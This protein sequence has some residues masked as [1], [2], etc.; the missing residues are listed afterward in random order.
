M[1]ASLATTSIGPAL[2]RSLLL[3]FALPGILQAFMHAPAGAILQGV[4]A[5]ESGI[6][7]MALGSAVLAVR[8]IDIFSDLL[9]GYLSDYTA[10]RGISRKL[11][12]AAGTVLTVLALWFLFRPP[13]QVSVMYYGFWF[14]MANIGWSLVEIP[15]RSWSLEFSPEPENRTRIVTWIAVASLVG[16]TVFYVVAPIG[17]ALGLLDT[18]EINM[19][20]LGLV[21]IVVA[22]FLPVL[23][24]VTLLRV[25]DTRIPEAPRPT[26]E[27]P[28][29]DFSL[30]WKSIV[31][32]APLLRFIACFALYT[33]MVGMSQ[34]VTLLYLTNYLLLSSSVNAVLASAA[35]IAVLGIPVWGWLCTK[36]PRQRVW[37]A[38]MGLA[39]VFY[40]CMGLLPPHPS[41][42]LMCVLNS[43]VAFCIISTVVAAPVIIGDII[44]YGKEKFGV[45]RAGLYLSFQGQVQ[46][47]IAAVASGAGL[48][49]LGW[50]G[51]DATLSG[52]D[53][54]P[55]AV[56]ALRWVVAW[57]PSL[58]FVLTALLL[59]IFPIGS[60]PQKP[61]TRA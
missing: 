44:D 51:F 52:A 48:I 6:A 46:K 11:W 33:F 31:G 45:E 41:V 32:N 17:K 12:M 23:N 9:I 55:Q 1:N 54:T 29:E 36:Y 4:Y 56:S 10:Q 42:A 2:S 58:G 14:L 43:M 5:K 8:I 18:A 53:L 61:M 22:L 24:L 40:G 13:P 27:M 19:R 28:K 37:A 39:G 26:G 35:P 16:G 50:A 7:L 21:A 30:L 60:S 47:G 20:L 34:G 49:F 59:W 38:G 15:Y 57:M 3:V 25:P